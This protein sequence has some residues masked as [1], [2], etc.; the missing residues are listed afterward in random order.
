EEIKKV[1]KKLARKYHPDVSKEE[2]AEDKFKQVSEAY[3]V[4]GNEEKRKQYDALGANWKNGQEFRPPPNWEEIFGSQF[5]GARRAHP[6]GGGSAFTFTS[7]GD[8]G[9]FSDFF[10]AIF[11]SQDF[12]QMMGGGAARGSGAHHGFAGAGGARTQPSRKGQDLETTV[13]IGL[14]EGLHGTKKQ[15]SFD[16]VS[17]KADGTQTT[18]KKSYQVKIPAGIQSGKTIR[19]TGQGAP[20]SAG[21]A[22]GDLLLKVNI[23][24]HPHFAIDG[25]NLRTELK[26]SPWEAALGTEI[27]LDT[28]D[29]T[30]SLKIPAGSQSGQKLRLKG[31]GY[32]DGKG[33]RGD[34]HV[35]LKIVVPKELSD[36]ERELFVSLQDSSSFNPRVSP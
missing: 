11:G 10:E 33:G 31:K 26:V 1:Y 5:G 34:L 25:A 4:L 2:G 21:G 16:L 27:P 19:L 8:A 30:V 14:Y 12:E 9:G 36:K 17:T 22:A 20:G 29:G 24:P 3:E 15:I 7:G 13:T 32:S 35:V 23:Q 6:G 18:E 28:L